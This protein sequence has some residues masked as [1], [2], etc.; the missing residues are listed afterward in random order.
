MYRSPMRLWSTLEKNPGRPGAS[1]QTCS[2]ASSSMAMCSTAVSVMASSQALQVGDQRLLVGRLD[3]DR[4]HLVAGLDRLGVADRA[5]QVAGGVGHGAGADRLTP[6]E[7]G[8]IGADRALGG[9]AADR[10][11]TGAREAHER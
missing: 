3:G 4:R 7:V 8:E 1:F 9:G 10:V 5:D 2:T 6:A 11:A